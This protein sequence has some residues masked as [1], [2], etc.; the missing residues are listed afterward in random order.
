MVFNQQKI[1]KKNY[2]NNNYYF[3]TELVKKSF[4]LSICSQYNLNN[5]NIT[6]ISLEELIDFF[7]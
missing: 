4:A 2:N 7:I 3:K 5:F 6:E 1:N